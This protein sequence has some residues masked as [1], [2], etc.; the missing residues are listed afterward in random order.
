MTKKLSEATLKARV[1]ANPNLG[2]P[3][4][5]CAGYAYYELD[6]P[7]MSDGLWEWLAKFLLEHWPRIEHRHKHLLSTDMLGS[8]TLLL[9]E[10]QTYPEIVKG[11]TGELLKARGA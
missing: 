10:G 7:F 6:R 1:K 3:L 8:G 5:L 2:V 9:S 11:A 4:Y